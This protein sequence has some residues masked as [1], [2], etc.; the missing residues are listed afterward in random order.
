LPPSEQATENNDEIIDDSTAQNE[1]NSN[2]D[3]SNE[4]PKE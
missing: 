4:S 3:E 2:A 1:E